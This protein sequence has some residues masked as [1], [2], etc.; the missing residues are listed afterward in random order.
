MRQ[1]FLKTI[2]FILAWSLWAL[3]VMLAVFE[4]LLNAVTPSTIDPAIPQAYVFVLNIYFT[5][6]VLSLPTVGALIASRHPKNPIGWLVGAIGLADF[7]RAAGGAYA[8]YALVVY[9]GSLPAGELAHWLSQ[10]G[11]AVTLGP[12]VFMILLFPNGR[13]LSRRWRPVT[14]LTAGAILATALVG[15][16]APLPLDE[17]SGS[18]RNPIGI[19]GP[20]G[21][22]LLQLFSILIQI[23]LALAVVA[24]LSLILRFRQAQGQERQQLKWFASAVAVASV[25][26]FAFWLPGGWS[27]AATLGVWAYLVVLPYVLALTTLPISIGIA[28][29]KYRLYE[30][31]LIIRRTLIYGSLTV[32]L[33]L[34]Y[35]GSI[36]FLQG[37]LPI[38]TDQSSPLAVV[39]STLAIAALFTPLR[40]RIQTVIDHRFYR[41]KYDTDKTLAAFSARLRDKVDLDK[42]TAGLVWVVDET[43]Q[44]THISLWLRDKNMK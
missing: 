22:A 7:V 12:M 37:L 42:L 39:A 23:Q 18:P 11:W 44:P 36:V 21:E 31:D 27:W 41:R 3:S 1:Q 24:A 33:T 25:V 5:L 6:M 28:I 4:L 40:R 29:L 13:L 15:A 43:M 20:I 8:R 14:W 26:S 9:P 34:V 16:F 35:F 10:M 19:E 30:I 38:L 2:A 17:I 32:A